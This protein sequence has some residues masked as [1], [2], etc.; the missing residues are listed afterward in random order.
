ML[1]LTRSGKIAQEELALED[2]VLKGLPTLP[3][4]KAKELLIHFFTF[5]G[6]SQKRNLSDA[7]YREIYSFV[8]LLEKN[9]RTFVGCY[10]I[11]LSN[12]KDTGRTGD[13][14]LILCQQI[15]LLA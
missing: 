13:I 15:I 12:L 8:R 2:N 14:R 6:E 5:V 10:N 9:L 7:S 1:D 3:D 11:T 4:Q